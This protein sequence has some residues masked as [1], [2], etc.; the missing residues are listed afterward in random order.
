M[1]SAILKKNGN[2]AVEESN[3]PK[4]NRNQSLVKVKNVGVNYPLVMGHE[5]SGEIVEPS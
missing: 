4:L 3:I 1:K 2:I 5:I